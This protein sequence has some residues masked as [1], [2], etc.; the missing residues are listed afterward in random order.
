IGNP[1][2]ASALRIASIEPPTIRLAAK[3]LEACRNSRRFICRPPMPPSPRHGSSR[4]H[5]LLPSQD[6]TQSI[7]LQDPSGK[8]AGVDGVLDDRHA[9]H[10][11]DRPIAGRI[12]MRILVSRPVTKI[13]GIE[14]RHIGAISGLEQAP[15]GKLER[16]RG[17]SSHLVD[18]E[19]ERDQREFAN[20]MAKNS[21]ERSIKT[22][23]RTAL[24]GDAVV[25]YTIA[26]GSYQ[27]QRRTQ[28]ITH[29]VLRNRRDK[30]A[31]GGLI[32]DQAVTDDI[33]WIGAPLAC[34]LCDGTPGI[35][36]YVRRD[37]NTHAVPIGYLAPVVEA[38][39][40]DVVTNLRA[41]LR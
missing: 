38:V 12:L 28:N 34:K 4:P 13:C 40:R 10:Q 2:S 36:W 20:V 30:H 16:T 18:R 19:L 14:N 31:R 39:A 41:G 27:R 5:H 7:A 1:V 35:L 32:F 33:N 11:H 6:L 29:V 8:C 26:V 24:T 22:W 9:V 23:V 37:R 3:T 21:R 25:S 17:R 15:V